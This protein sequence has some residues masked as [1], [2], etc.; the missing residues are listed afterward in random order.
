MYDIPA[1]TIDG[2]TKNPIDVVD[3]VIENQ[4]TSLTSLDIIF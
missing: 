1:V 3:D 2:V 4:I